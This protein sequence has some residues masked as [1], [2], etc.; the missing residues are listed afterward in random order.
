M[1][2]SPT[3]YLRSSRGSQS[4]VSTSEILHRHSSTPKSSPPQERERSL[5]DPSGRSVFDYF[6]GAIHN[7]K[8]APHYR[9]LSG[10]MCESIHIKHPN[11]EVSLAMKCSRRTNYNGNNKICEELVA[12][13]A[14]SHTS[15]RTLTSAR[16]DWLT[17]WLPG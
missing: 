2:L 7:I 3:V 1:F 12:S 8:E 10:P 6:Y 16:L 9:H 14:L 13:S 15:L 11:Y 5:I 4:P 17:G